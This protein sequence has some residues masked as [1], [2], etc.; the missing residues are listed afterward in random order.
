[1][2]CA[3]ADELLARVRAL[4]LANVNAEPGAEQH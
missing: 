2:E 3:S 1:M 4:G